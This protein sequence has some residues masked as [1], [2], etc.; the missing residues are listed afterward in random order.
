MKTFNK[1]RTFLTLILTVLLVAS[2]VGTWVVASAFTIEQPME[3]QAAV[4][5][6]AGNNRVAVP[7]SAVVSSG[8]V[9]TPV[10]PEKTG[11]IF[12]GWYLDEDLTIPY[13]GE[14]ITADL[15]LYAAFTP[16]TYKVTLQRNNSSIGGAPSVTI[17]CTYDVSFKLERQAMWAHSGYR[18]TYWAKNYATNQNPSEM[19]AEGST[20]KNLT[21]TQGATVTLW[22]NW[23]T[24]DYTLAFNANGGTGTMASQTELVG[25]NVTL[26]TN[27]FTRTG[28]TFAGWA[29]S[30]S[31]SVAYAD[32]AS[33]KP[34][35]TEGGTTTL[36][37]VWT[38]NTYTINFVNTYG[39]GTM[40]SKSMT[41]NVSAN[42]NA[43]T[44]VRE[45][46]NFAG[47]ATSAASG[48]P[49]V[50]DDKAS[51]KNLTSEAD[52]TYTL[53]ALWV[54]ASYTVSFNSNGGTGTMD[55]VTHTEDLIYVLPDNTFTR[56]GYLFAG[57]SKSASATTATWVD[58]DDAQDLS[59]QGNNV[60]LYAVWTPVTYTV[61][62]VNTYGGTGSTASQTMTYNKS[63]N[64]SANGF[65]RPGYR[66]VGW[67]TSGDSGAPVN[68][69]DKQSVKNLASAQ[70]A[71]VTLYARWEAIEYTVTF[72]ANGGTGTMADQTLLVGLA[73]NLTA[74][75]FAR[76]GYTFAGWAESTTGA[77]KYSDKQSVT[78]LVAEG[79][80]KTLY[81]VWTANTYTIKF[82][83][84]NASAT[85]T[86]ADMS[87]TYDIAKNLTA[88]AFVY[89]GYNFSHWSVNEPNTANPSA[90]K[91]DKASVKNLTSTNGGTVTLF[92]VWVKAEYTVSFDA[93]GG[94]GTLASVTHQEDLSYTL[95]ANT[96]TKTGYLFEGWATSSTGSVKYLDKASVKDL[97]T[98][99]NNVTLYA[100]W[101]PIN[102]TI[103][104]NS[105]GGTGTMADMSMTYDVSKSLP[106]NTFTKTGYVF[107]GWSL[108]TTSS[109]PVKYLDKAT[110]S[111]LK[112]T[113]GATITL[114]A[115][116]DADVYT[117]KF[118]ANGGE[119][120]MSNQTFTYDTEGTL[121]ANSFTREGYTFLGWSTTK[122]GAVEYSDTEAVTNIAGSN[123]SVTLYA[124]WKINTYTVTIMVDGEVYAVI[125]V[126]WGTPSEEVLGE[127]VDPALYETEGELP[128]A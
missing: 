107:V 70:G 109:E 93:N 22:A 7:M 16:I 125:V 43:N 113:D 80:T 40:A 6:S 5:P 103:K 128:N 28:Y 59:T 50:Y 96:F 119:G 112:N 122:G 118:D 30:A 8:G 106:E 110:V 52:G 82:E 108:G 69:T 20:V 97:S 32:G 17:N 53:Y 115:H 86:M 15:T 41:Y 36:Y 58:G 13:E 77:V 31:G 89:P 81:A 10:V 19:Y 116:W 79:E 104:F 71:E 78:S 57:W 54:E 37:A 92:A 60:T 105:N 85:G 27:T 65:V 111:N 117:V 62:F 51:V 34:A 76:T 121:T 2:L 99:G 102:Y 24:I 46:Y 23:E 26:P 63:A 120:T 3:A 42:L 55:S 114:Y 90:M 98:Q 91:A 47:W 9:T 12:A 100:I 84:N 1:T 29:T 49:K 18:L 94:T 68:Y 45:G 44:F 11:Y 4:E 21:T 35:S 67:A 14:L 48:A 87:M 56:T 38:P 88:N 126:E 75:S 33:V 72:N 83:K 61:K 101:S 74:N 25:Q 64:L 123:S 66:F 39:G 124:V 95:P 73:G 127:A